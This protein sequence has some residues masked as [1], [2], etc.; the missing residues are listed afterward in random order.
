MVTVSQ[1]KWI[2]LKPASWM[3]QHTWRWKVVSSEVQRESIWTS[4]CWAMLTNQHFWHQRYICD[5]SFC[6]NV[7]SFFKW[8]SSG[9]VSSDCYL[10]I[11]TFSAVKHHLNL[12][13][14]LWILYF[15]A[16]MWRNKLHPQRCSV[17]AKARKADVIKVRGNT[18]SEYQ[19]FS[20][21][22][23]IQMGFWCNIALNMLNIPPFSS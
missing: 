22:K 12:V 23:L 2:Q 1:R 7:T 17:V 18:I 3:K 10:N 21:E 5:F 9:T 13:I 19:L 4:W 16:E 14:S 6:C 15:F 20:H 11:K 8:I